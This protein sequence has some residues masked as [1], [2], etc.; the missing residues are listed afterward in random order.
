MKVVLTG[1]GTAG[2]VAINKILIPFLKKEQLDIIYIGSHKGMENDLVGSIKEVTYYGISTG[3]L[4]RYA[5]WENVT[6]IFRVI[7]GIWNAYTILK[8]EAPQVV[9]SCGGY[10]TVPV[11]LAASILR[12]PVLIRETDYTIGLA[13][14]ICIRFAKKIFVTFEDTCKKIKDVHCAYQGTIIGPHLFE[15]KSR[16][17]L[18]S[19][20]CKPT[21]LFVGGS[22]G[23]MKINQFIWDNI[24]ELTLRYQIIHICGKGNFCPEMEDNPAYRQFEFVHNMS[25]FYASCDMVVTRCGSNAIME[26]LVLGKRMICIPISGKTSRGEQYDNGAF[27]VKHGNAVLLEESNLSMANMIKAI[28]EVRNKPINKEMIRTN[29]EVEMNCRRQVE[30]ICKAGN[31]AFS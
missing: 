8:K 10:V 20:N 21:I 28:K 5:S 3:K 4:R 13:N 2:H 15:G 9:Y 14:R 23:A 19:F 12:I 11:V 30:E 1:G 17:D 27:A 22:L 16:E 7:Q 31:A 6:D 18:T 29:R 26:G 25:D 24:E